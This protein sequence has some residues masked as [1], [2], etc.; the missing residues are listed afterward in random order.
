MD[1]QQS[2]QEKKQVQLKASDEV[3]KGFYANAMIT[4]HTKEEFILDFLSIFGQNGTVGARIIT[5]PGHFKRMIKALEGALKKYEESF[6]EIKEAE[7]VDK[8]IGFKG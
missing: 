5:S 6:G 8:E 4:N 2:N 7:E 3:V 1:N